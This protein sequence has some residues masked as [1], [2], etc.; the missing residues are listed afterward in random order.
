MVLITTKKTRLQGTSKE[1][2]TKLIGINIT[3][4][5]KGREGEEREKRLMMMTTMN[6]DQ[7]F[8]IASSD[9]GLYMMTMIIRK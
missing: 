8:S 2:T 3:N 6:L 9:L 5:K 4:K 7:A 1:L